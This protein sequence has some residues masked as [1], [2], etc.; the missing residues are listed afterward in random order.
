MDVQ[1]GVMFFIE[2]FNLLCP[3]HW[4]GLTNYLRPVGG[5]FA[6]YF[7]VLALEVYGSLA[8]ICISVLKILGKDPL[9]PTGRKK[10]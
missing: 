8:K 7:L 3:L 5:L 10:A 2:V 4:E 9:L 6:V 1:Y